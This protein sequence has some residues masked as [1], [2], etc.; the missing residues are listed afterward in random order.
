MI[1]EVREE[2]EDVLEVIDDLVINR[3]GACCDIDEVFLDVGEAGLETT[4][5]RELF[6]DTSGKGSGGGVFDVAKEMF[7]ADLFCF[8]CVDRGGDMEERFACF[9]A[10]LEPM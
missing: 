3:E 6:R 10:V 5:R 8:F 1:R 7:D 2:V 9:C 4:E